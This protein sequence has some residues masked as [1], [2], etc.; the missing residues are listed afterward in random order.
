MV[1]HEYHHTL[2]WVAPGY[3]RT[4]GEAL[5][6]EGLAGR[7]ARE[8]YDNPPEHYESALEPNAFDELA[9]LALTHWDDAGYDHP[10]WFFGARNLPVHVGYTLGYALVGEYLDARADRERGE[11]GARARELVPAGPSGARGSGAAG[12]RDAKDRAARVDR[13]PAIIR[14]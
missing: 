1:A 14:R 3:G 9:P 13:R 5:V 2:R 6:S 7:F 8:L 11:P 12:V 10:R 4:L